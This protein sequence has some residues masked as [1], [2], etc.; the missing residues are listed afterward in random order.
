MITVREAQERILATFELLPTEKVGILDALGRV[1]AEDI[2]AK[3]NIPPRNNSAMDGYAVRFEDTKGASKKNPVILDI[4]EEIPAGTFPKKKIH[5][6]QAACVMTGAPLPEG[7][8]AVVR[9]EDTRR[10]GR[11]IFIFTEVNPNT[12]VRYAGEDVK[13][14]E[15]VLPRGTVIR[16]PEVGMLA[17]LGRAFVEVHQ[18]PV[19][20][21]LATGDEIIDIDEGESPWKT[22]SSNTYSTMAQVK[23]CG[24]IPVNLGI[25]KDR[26]EDLIEKLKAGLRADI[27]ITSGGVSVGEYDLVKHVMGDMGTVQF[28]QIAMRPG[29]PLAF[30]TIS[31]TP[32]FG[33]PGNPVSS[34]VTF[35]QFVRPS[36][37]KMMGFRK[38]FRPVIRAITT[39][40]IKKKKGFRYFL[41]GVVEKKEKEFYVTTTGAQ[42]SGILKSMV[43]ANALIVLPE[44]RE[45]ILSG[46]EVEVQLLENIIDRDSQMG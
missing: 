30:G 37:L 20:A 38:L 46:E 16:P 11:K 35:E 12:D 28:W 36:L 4:V 34:M 41:R 13:E 26:R 24:A 18:R 2:W 10:E 5:P 43:K 42:G 3:R 25:A 14:G 9:V 21:I 40:N 1:L 6:G 45:S 31:E 7:A 15:L 32:I 44:E 23:E 17:A 22:I 27:I 39:E 29:K 33:L 8:N 19:V